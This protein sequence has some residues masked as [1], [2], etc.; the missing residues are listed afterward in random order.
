MKT[1]KTEKSTKEVKICA[2]FQKLDHVIEGSR[3]VGS[4]KTIINN[5]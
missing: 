4:S 2:A 1:V 5:I 3:L